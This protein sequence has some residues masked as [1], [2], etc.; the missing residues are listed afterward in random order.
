MFFFYPTLQGYNYFILFFKIFYEVH[1]VKRMQS[2]GQNPT[3]IKLKVFSVSKLITGKICVKKIKHQFASFLKSRSLDI[4]M[5]N[6]LFKDLFFSSSDRRNEL[7]NH[8]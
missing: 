5:C 6:I 3:K 7:N 1:F 4:F 2:M 8:G